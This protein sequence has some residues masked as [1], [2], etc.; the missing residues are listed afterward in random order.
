M[1]EVYHFMIY[2]VICDFKIIL[3][4][5]VISSVRVIYSEKTPNIE[6]TL[7]NPQNARPRFYYCAFLCTKQ[8]H[9]VLELILKIIIILFLA[10]AKKHY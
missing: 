10:L 1:L 9:C 4:H 3:I 5:L 8:Y 2:K 7:F 6:G